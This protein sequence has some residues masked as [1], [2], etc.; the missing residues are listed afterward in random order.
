MSIDNEPKPKQTVFSGFKGDLGIKDEA[1]GT[2]Y[3]SVSL[4]GTLNPGY[5]YHVPDRAVRAVNEML[6]GYITPP[7]NPNFNR[8]ETVKT[9][10]QKADKSKNEPLT[11][12]E[13]GVLD[14]YNEL[15]K[16]KDKITNGIISS[17]LLDK[18]IYNIKTGLAYSDEHISRA[19][20]SLRGKGKKV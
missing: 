14:V 12:L 6:G 7:A 1:A 8:D 15:K 18:G 19:R 3:L 16:Q 5:E 10:S 11:Q 13:K 17:K 9:I 2:I 4:D 20:S